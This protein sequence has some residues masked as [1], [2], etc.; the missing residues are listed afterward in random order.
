MGVGCRDSTDRG[1][2]LRLALAAGFGHDRAR[3]VAD[4]WLSDSDA[5]FRMAGLRILRHLG[6]PPGA[7]LARV[8]ALCESPETGLAVG[9]RLALARA[10]EDCEGALA[11]W[12]S[13]VEHAPSPLEADIVIA[14]VAGL[15]A[16]MPGLTT[17]LR[18]AI[19]MGPSHGLAV[20]TFRMAGRP[21]GSVSVAF[22]L[23]AP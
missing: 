12:W 19:L 2:Y 13:L 16:D 22:A 10:G 4:G 1:E 7:T 23:L 17:S 3:A 11:A 14:G 21:S 20:E 8:R 5:T 18:R 15:P 9:A 6:V